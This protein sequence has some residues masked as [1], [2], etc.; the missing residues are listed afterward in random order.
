MTGSL[1]QVVNGRHGARLRPVVGLSPRELQIIGTV[2]QMQ[3]PT[4]SRGDHFLRTVQQQGAE[5]Q[6]RSRSLRWQYTFLFGELLL[7]I[8]V[9]TAMVGQMRLGQDSEPTAVQGG[10]VQGD[11]TGDVACHL[12]LKRRI[13]GQPS[14]NI[15]RRSLRNGVHV[16]AVVRMPANVPIVL[17]M[18]VEQDASGDL[19]RCR[20]QLL[21]DLQY[22]SEL[23]DPRQG[24]RL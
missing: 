7:G 16:D 23:Q 9:V 3:D 6:R 10:R 14:T 8:L 4:P 15:F 18:F 2:L 22:G 12:H 24:S 20:Y 17:G 19:H 13:N 21:N 5:T 11:A 1:D